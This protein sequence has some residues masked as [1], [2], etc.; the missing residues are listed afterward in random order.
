MNTYN[1]KMEL[2]HWIA[3]LQDVSI[4]A[5][6]RS[7]KEDIPVLTDAESMSIE[8]GLKDFQQGKVY[9]HLQV[10]KRYEKWL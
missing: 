9:P 7:I 8:K 10:K 2:I 4:L 1:E 5:K 3:E 6:I